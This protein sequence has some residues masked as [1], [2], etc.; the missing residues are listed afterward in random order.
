MSSLD[1]ANQGPNRDVSFTR[2][3]F[4]HTLTT[5]IRINVRSNELVEL[6]RSVRAL[7]LL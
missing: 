5:R 1:I 3:G 6:S 7:R 4:S 2:D